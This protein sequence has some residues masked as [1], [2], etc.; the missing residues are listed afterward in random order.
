MEIQRVPGQ[1]L[2]LPRDEQVRKM[3]ELSAIDQRRK[4]LQLGQGQGLRLHY[5]GMFSCVEILTMLYLRWMRIRP[6]EPDWPERDRFLLSK[7]HAAPALYA[8]LAAC[9]FFAESEFRKFRRLHGILQ[10]HPDRNKTP[11]VDCSTGSLGQ[12][13]PVACGLGLAAKMDGA[14]YRV[15]T[16]LSDGECNEG[17]IWEA[18]M[19]AANLEIDTVTAMLDWNKMSSYGPMKGR[20]DVEP[21][22]DKWLAFGWH[23]LECDGHDFIALSAALSAAQECRRKPS[24]I[25]C[26]TRKNRGIPSAEGRHMPSNYALD[27]RSYR[28]ALAELEQ[29]ERELRDGLAAG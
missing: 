25:L 26:H 16:L 14:P 19:I 24:I 22:A 17:S 1:P 7:G 13:F 15:F 20:N 4:L 9:G 12:G 11:G 3:L 5:G 10:G 8:V 23:V 6:S 29:R 2:L 28:E 27:G 21:L 18:A